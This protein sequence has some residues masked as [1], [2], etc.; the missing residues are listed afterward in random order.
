[1]AAWRGLGIG[2][3]G[4]IAIAIGIAIEPERAL[5]AYLAVWAAAVTMAAGAL[6]V[7]LIGYAAN[8]RWPATLRRVGEL[9]S[10][11]LAPLAVLAIP[12]LVLAA[13]VWPWVDPG[14][15]LR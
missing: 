7:M 15:E 2:I 9:A 3:V 4:A 10:L 13:H 1:M 5:A 14:P 11:A 6:G 12:L 8:S